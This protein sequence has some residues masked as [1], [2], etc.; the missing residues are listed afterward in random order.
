MFQM[1]FFWLA[2]QIIKI[3]VTTFIEIISWL[4]NRV[5]E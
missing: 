3:N 1:L 5:G 2:Y 4:A